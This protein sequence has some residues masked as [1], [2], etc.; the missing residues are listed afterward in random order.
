MAANVDLITWTDS[1]LVESFIYQTAG[2]E[3][4]DLTGY[5]LRLM[6]RR[7]AG[8]AT[9]EFE[10]STFNGRIWFNDAENGAFTLQI[11]VDILSILSP[12]SYVQSLIATAPSP[13]LLRKDVWRGTLEHSDGPTRW[14]LG[15][16]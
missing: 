8:D 1:D 7:F 9:A 13:S 12:G 11:P 5:S 2:G 15:T 14:D 10:C 16:Q 3:P 6:V 4:I